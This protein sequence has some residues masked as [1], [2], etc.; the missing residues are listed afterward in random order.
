MVVTAPLQRVWGTPP[1]KF[2]HLTPMF[3]VAWTYWTAP[4]MDVFRAVPHGVAYRL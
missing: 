4:V 3:S 2:V 1:A